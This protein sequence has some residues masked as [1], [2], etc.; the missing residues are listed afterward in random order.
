MREEQRSPIDAWLQEDLDAS[1]PGTTAQDPGFAERLEQV[2]LLYLRRTLVHASERSRLYSRRLAGHDLAVDCEEK[3]RRLPFTMPEDLADCHELLC[4]PA[5][6]VQRIVTMRTSGSSGTPKRIMFTRGDLQRTVSFFAAGMSPLV[7]AGERLLVMLPGAQRPDG[8]A[9]LLRQ[10]LVP[11]DI[12]V[13]AADPGIELSS[14]EEDFLL[15]R[16]DILVAG[17]E[18]LRKLLELSNGHRAL[19]EALS[20]VQ[21][22]LSSGDMLPGDLRSA[23][24]ASWGCRVL[25][26]WGMTETCFG[27]G[28]ECLSRCGYHLRELDLFIEILS[29]LTGMPVREGELGEIVVTT[30]RREAMPLIRYRTGDA[31]RWLEGPCPCG[32]PLRRLSSIEG[33][34]VRSKGTVGLKHIRKGAHDGT[35][36]FKTPA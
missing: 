12:T 34:Y 23:M 27:G 16:P 3:L 29:P 17:P 24:E 31:A 1:F 26:H 11:G 5:G 9:D 6:D 2:R 13:K 33:R 35:D 4:V 36:P 18:Q 14:L 22:I 19:R 21:G 25:D 15:Y 30:L 10:A 28:V 8:V 32:S 20:C 7:H